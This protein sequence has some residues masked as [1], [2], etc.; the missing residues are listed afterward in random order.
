MDTSK[1]VFYI[2][3][4]C[5]PRWRC[6]SF[7]SIHASC[8]CVIYVLGRLMVRY[9]RKRRTLASCAGKVQWRVPA[10]SITVCA[11][12]DNQGLLFDGSQTLNIAKTLASIR[13]SLMNCNKSLSRQDLVFMKK[14]LQRMIYEYEKVLQAPRNSYANMRADGRGG[15]GHSKF[16]HS[17]RL[18]GG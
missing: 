16:K 11:R 13:T 12:R 4:A 18:D 10:V 15:R 6:S 2:S 1:E 17:L 8:H 9:L 7:P 14:Y 3:T 5:D